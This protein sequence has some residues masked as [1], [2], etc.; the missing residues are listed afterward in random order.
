MT[1]DVAYRLPAEVPGT[2]TERMT[3]AFSTSARSTVGIEW[4]L[5]LADEATGDLVGRAPE[6]MPALEESTAL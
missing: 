5:M 2:H 3:I 1:E 4:E 6:I